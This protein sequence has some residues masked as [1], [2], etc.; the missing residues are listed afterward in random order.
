MSVVINTNSDALRIQNTLTSATDK[1]SKSMQRMSSGLKITAAKDDAAG[2]VI[3]ARMAVQLDGNK[4]C[5]QNVQNANSLLSTAEG[6]LDIVLDNITRIRDLTLQA[7]NGTYSKEEIT[8]MQDEVTQRIAEIDRVSDSSKFSQLQLFG[9]DDLKEGAT[10]QVGTNS[11]EENVI[12]VTNDDNIFSSVKFNDLLTTATVDETKLVT[13]FSATAE[14]G[15]VKLSFSDQKFDNMRDFWAAS[16]EKDTKT[17]TVY[18][19]GDKYYYA[20]TLAT[21][22]DGTSA[23]SVECSK[24]GVKS[25]DITG[26]NM[27]TKKTGEGAY[28]YA[29]G[30]VFHSNGD[31]EKTAGK[32]YVVAK[33]NAS[34]EAG[35]LVECDSA[36]NI[37]VDDISVLA[38]KGDTTSLVQGLRYYDKAT[39][40]YYKVT[41]AATAEKDAELTEVADKYGTA[42]KTQSELDTLAA[43]AT[44]GDIKFNKDTGKYQ[45]FDSNAYKT[46]DGTAKAYVDMDELNSKSIYSEKNAFDLSKMTQADFSKA[47]DALDSAIDDITARKSSIGSFENRLESAMNSLTTQFTNLTSAKSII[48][49]SDIASEAS[50]FTQNQILQQVSTSLL[51]QANQAPS[52]AMSLI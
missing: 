22:A 23:V 16:A 47:L 8:A 4:I 32:Y 52:V 5:Q 19:V 11:G 20:T 24:E 13:Q 31:T 1:L 2:T 12:K 49:D 14:G 10:F 44:D 38:K 42:I 26:T 48:T 36:G 30:T 21:K 17:N 7:K 29:V 9:S 34:A 43:S 6:N 51:A 25:I 41:G 37:E 27:A 45:V 40:K 46:Y 3:S 33:N 50:T 39:D 28:D 15:G 35:N 18:Q